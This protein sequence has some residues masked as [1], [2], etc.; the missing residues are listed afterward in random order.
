MTLVEFVAVGSAPRARGTVVEDGAAVAAGRFSPACAGNGAPSRL[1]MIVTTV[2]PRV[3][4]E[5][6]SH[7]EHLATSHGSAPRA[8]GTDCYAL[9]VRHGERFSP[10]CAGNGWGGGASRQ[11]VNGSAP[12]ARGTAPRRLHDRAPGRFSPACAGNGHPPKSS[13]KRDFHDVKRSTGVGTPRPCASRA[14]RV[15]ALG[16]RWRKPDECQAVEVDGL[17]PVFADGIEGEPRVG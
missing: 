9:G 14:R 6:D 8:R 13:N 12:R 10:A 15:G 17:T 16:G 4:G 2:Q 7:F 1:L 5:R 3:R 11:P